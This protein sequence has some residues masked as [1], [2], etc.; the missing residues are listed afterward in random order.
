M[1]DCVE[2]DR[3]SWVDMP[4]T[5]GSTFAICVPPRDWS[6][7]GRGGGCLVFLAS[8]WVEAAPCAGDV[9]VTCRDVS[10]Y[11]DEYVVNI[12]E[13]DEFII[14]LSS[15]QKRILSYSQVQLSSAAVLRR[16]RG[17]CEASRET[18]PWTTRA[19]G[20]VHL[21]SK[22]VFPIVHSAPSH[23]LAIQPEPRAGIFAS[24]VVTRLHLHAPLSAMNRA[25]AKDLI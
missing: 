21:H 8:C 1:S 20:Q 6:R 14:Q 16:W 7:G 23:F 18:A 15:T 22:C 19:T 4:I 3:G 12:H 25:P 2:D 5:E 11:A 10:G 17:K 9:I 24:E 13:G